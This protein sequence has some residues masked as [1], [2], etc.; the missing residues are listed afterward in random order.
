MII[1]E[2]PEKYAEYQE[3]DQ[4]SLLGMTQDGWVVIALLNS[5]T[6]DSRQSNKP[7][8]DGQ[9]YSQSNYV[10]EAFVLNQPRYL[11]GKT[12]DKV[13]E[14]L[15]ESEREAVQNSKNH[16]ADA[17][18]FKEQVEGKEKTIEAKEKEIDQQH[19]RI[20]GLQEK[21]NDARSMQQKME[22]DLAKVRKAVGDIKFKEIVGD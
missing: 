17:T 21:A 9:G 10:E 14:E 8:V 7:Y 5:S 3:V 15:R 11:I 1:L 16:Q 18:V 12:R 19:E 13:L 2:N 4:H 20:Q 22:G 6:I